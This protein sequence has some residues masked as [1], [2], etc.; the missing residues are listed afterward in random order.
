[1]RSAV[2]ALAL[3][4]ALAFA[5][6]SIARPIPLKGTVGPGFTIV[7]TSAAGKPVKS[8]KAG[9]YAITVTDKSAIHNFRLIGKGVNKEI[10]SI[11]F[12]GK[13]T[14]TV[15]LRAGRVIYQCDPHVSSMKGS[16]RVTR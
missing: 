6:A 10:T 3:G 9:R 2:A 1:M 8:L 11:A 13:K 7:L 16:F 14:I 15:T 12:T 5:P 4:A